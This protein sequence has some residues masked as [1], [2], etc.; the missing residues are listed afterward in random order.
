MSQTKIEKLTPQQE[1]L[2]PVYREKWRKIA[3]STEAI[4]R[5]KAANSIKVA[6]ELIGYQE[7][8]IIFCDSPFVLCNTVVSQLES[9][10]WSQLE[11]QLER[12]LW[13][14]LE[15]QL[16][17]L[18]WQLYSQLDSELWNQIESQL[19]KPLESPLVGSLCRTRCANSHNFCSSCYP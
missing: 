1:A 4:D 13:S 11:S 19:W 18:W 6:Y 15:N 10:L 12:H 2:I 17:Q 7:P 14:Q 5:Q 3:L 16:S 8:E 9:E